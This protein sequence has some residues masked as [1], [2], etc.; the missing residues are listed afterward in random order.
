[1]F[2]GDAARLDR[3]IIEIERLLTD[4]WS[5]SHE[6]EEQL[7]AGDPGPW[8]CFLCTVAG[9]RPASTVTLATES[10]GALYVSNIVPSELPSLTHDQYNAVLQGFHDRFACPAAQGIGVV[11]ELGDPDPQ[12]EDFLSA[13]TARLL[14]S[15]SALAN[16]SV[17]H[18]LDRQ[19][20]N[21]FLTAAHREQAPLSPPMLARW[22]IEEEKW[23]EDK[24]TDLI[25]EYE[26]A[27]E[28][29]EVYESQQV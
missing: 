27:Q 21:E 15:F 11:I 23:P 10:D 14:H 26:N 18:P 24:A 13:H 12:I 5:R 29:L 20:W 7:R 19:R 25:I 3:L 17:L 28:L 1:M 4:G 9:S 22:L 6:L 8:Y 16:R 2:P